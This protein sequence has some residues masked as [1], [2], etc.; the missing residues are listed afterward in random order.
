[1]IKPIKVVS[2]PLSLIGLGVAGDIFSPK[3]GGKIHW[4]FLG[5]IPSLL[6]K[7]E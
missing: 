4:E 2:F 1:M 7:Y 5:K 6:K 3:T